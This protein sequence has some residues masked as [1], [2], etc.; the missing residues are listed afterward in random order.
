MCGAIART[1][2]WSSPRNHYDVGREGHTEVLQMI[3]EAADGL[4]DG[5]LAGRMR[6]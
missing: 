2:I 1:L 3:E 6:P 5:L 4:V